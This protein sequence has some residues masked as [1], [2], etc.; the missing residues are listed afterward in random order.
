MG[1]EVGVGTVTTSCPVTFSGDVC[2]EHW[3]SLTTGLLT[4][5]RKALSGQFQI[6]L[7]AGKTGCCKGSQSEE[8][9]FLVESFF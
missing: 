3:S 8:A 2:A 1:R 6:L 5:F 7:E 4:I 9:A